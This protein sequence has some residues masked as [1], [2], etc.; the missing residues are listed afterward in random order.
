MRTSWRRILFS[1]GLSIG[2]LLFLRQMWVSYGAIRHHEFRLLQP[3]CLLAALALSMLVY[4]L[5]MLAWA[6][7]MRYLGVSLSLRQTLQ[8]FMLSFLPR[9][10]PGSVWGYWSR[11][12]WLEQSCGI[13]YATST[14]GSVLEAAALIMTSLSLAGVYLYTRL[15]G[16][17]R[18]VL[19]GACA[20]LL[21]LIWRVIPRIAARLINRLATR[22]GR[23]ST[24]S[25]DF[26]KEGPSHVWLVAIALYIALWVTY[27]GSILLIGNGVVPTP[28]RDL[29]GIIFSSSLSWL[30]GFVVV[31]VPT[32]IGV[33]EL[34][35]STLLS[36]Y[37][38][39][40]PWQADLVAVISR[41]EIILAELGWLVVGLGLHAHRW[42]RG[43]GQP[44]VS[45]RERE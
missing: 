14:L 23:E 20:G 1:V 38:G 45:T 9:Y 7:I 33:R 3:A 15:T 17:R 13:D 4:I 22:L 24:K 21:W 28:S 2:L 34:S 25:R 26:R 10:I 35:L 27:G 8:G 18:F 12:Q 19:A 43:R 6:I 41:F 30:L 29:L 40:L 37:S 42:R 39:L 44:E 11:S 36:V 5:Q 32:G 31:F 16:F